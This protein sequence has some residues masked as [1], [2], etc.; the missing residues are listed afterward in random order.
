M[1]GGGPSS[2]EWLSKAIIRCKSAIQNSKSAADKMALV[3]SLT[4]LCGGRLDLSDVPVQL[5]GGDFALLARFGLARTN[6]DQSLRVLREDHPEGLVGLDEALRL[7]TSRRQLYQTASPDAVLLRLTNHDRYRTQTQ[8]AATRALLTQPPGSGLLVSMPTGSGKSLLFQLAANFGRETQAG[9]CAVVVTPTIALALD[10]ERTLS[11]MRGL[12]TSR[13]LTS[14]TSPADVEIILNGFRR[15]EIPI[16]LLSP[17]KALSAKLAAVLHEAALPHSVEY[18]LEA[19]LTHFFIDEAHIV[20]TW[21]RSFRPDFQRLPDLLAQLRGANPTLRA[22]LLSATLPE[23]AREVLRDSWKLDGDWLEIDARLPRYEHD[24]VVANYWKESA[25]DTAL[26]HTID[27]APRP[28]IIY[29][30]EIAAATSIYRQLVGERGGYS[31]AA[32]FTGDTGTA[33][34]RNTVNGWAADAY[35]IVVATSAFGMGIDKPDVRSIIHA[36]LPEGPSR[37]YQ[38]IGRASRDGGQGLAACLFLE[39]DGMNDW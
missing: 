22:V 3:R 10:H 8:K 38:E 7:D 35:D 39:G 13:A 23:G 37:W 28:L 1:S 12:E 32:L 17:E 9:A 31:R 11:K 30:T 21:G 14:D 4:R 34:R 29:T 5:D 25:R 36:C 24:I 15:G 19:R 16:L 6:S 33:E 18:G 26:F 2:E 20:E 27:R